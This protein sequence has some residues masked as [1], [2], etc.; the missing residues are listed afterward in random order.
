MTMLDWNDTLLDYLH[1][2]NEDA[3]VVRFVSDE[4]FPILVRIGANI[5][6]L[7]VGP[8]PGTKTLP[9][10]HGLRQVT[11]ERLRSLQ[12]LEPSPAWR[13]YL[14]TNN[15]ALVQLGKLTEESFESHAHSASQHDGVFRPNFI[16]CFHVLYDS[17][18]AEEFV[19]FL[20]SLADAGGAVLAC[21]IVESERSDFFRMRQL[22]QPLTGV[23]PTSAV[24]QLRTSIRR[25]GLKM[26][27]VEVNS[28][29]CKL[30]EDCETPDWLLPF[31][32]GCQKDQV[33][34]LPP[35][36]RGQGLETIRRFII[37]KGRLDLDVPDTAFI[38]TTR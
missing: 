9:I 20:K 2:S 10:A 6:W 18:L 23:H 3:R 14:R 22:L 7:E 13:D 37:E 31:L 19:V 4:L 17:L 1:T 29:H 21:V 16:T 30:S 5:D 32:M 34:S 28:Q 8:G 33:R 12:M 27:E 11:G 38:I 26:T 36:I 35:Q 24:V 25:L 15:P